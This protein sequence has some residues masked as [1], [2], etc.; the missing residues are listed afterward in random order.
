M[1][2]NLNMTLRGEPASAKEVIMK[3]LKIERK[4]LLWYIFVALL[5]C[6]TV[7]AF[8]FST[9]LFGP[10]SIFSKALTGNAFVDW[11]FG[12][13]PSAVRTVQVITIAI[14]VSMLTRYFMRKGLAKS[15]RGLTIVRL[16][17]NFIRWVIAIIT[18][19]VILAAWGVDTTAIIA[20][21][22]ILTLVVGLGAQSLVADVVAGIFMV[23]EGEFQI[24]DIVIINDWRGTVQEIGIRTTKLVDAGGNVNIINNNEI[25]TVVNQSKAPSVANCRISIEYGESIPRVEVVIRDNL[26]RLRAAIPAITEGPYYKGVD[27]LGSSSVDLLVIAKCKEEDIFQVQRDMNRE[28]KLLFDENGINI[29]FPQITINKPPVFVGR[30]S[31]SQN[32]EARAFVK[33]QEAQSA[34]VE[35]END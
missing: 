18:V 5:A 10:D 24:G 30:D 2:Y 21:A 29:P 6:G 7:A 35:D 13:I 26:D 32:R 23:F 1:C 22:G 19:L 4:K 33:E 11:L 17:E 14:L 34:G 15:N 3:F 28:L 27:K 31:E 12:H 16:L 9:Q 8:V 20:S 25:K